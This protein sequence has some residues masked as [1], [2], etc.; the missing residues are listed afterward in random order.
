MHRAIK[1]ET[2]GRYRFIVQICCL[3][4]LKQGKRFHQITNFIRKQKKLPLRSREA[5]RFDRMYFTGNNHPIVTRGSR[6][7]RAPPHHTLPAFLNLHG[8]F[9]QN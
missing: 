8:N 9:F 4:D 1:A 5:G 3:E 7:S 2:P 6:F